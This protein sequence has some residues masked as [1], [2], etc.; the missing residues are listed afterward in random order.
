MISRA[1]KSK[2]YFLKGYN[3]AQS[4]LLAY[5]DLIA[6]DEKTCALLGSSFGGGIGGMRQVCGAVCSMEMVVGLIK[7]YESPKV[8]K[9]KRE[10]YHTV[11]SLANKFKEKNGSLICG[12]LLGLEGFSLPSERSEKYYKKRPCAQYVYDCALI[13]EEFL[14]K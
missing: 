1:Q 9:E 10:H 12:Q 13:L 4:V 11:Q 7:G 8:L 2:E 6:L 14:L 3:C 5:C